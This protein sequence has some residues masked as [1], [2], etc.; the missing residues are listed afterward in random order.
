M[1]LLISWFVLSLAVWLTSLILP[2]FKVRGFIGA[3]VVAAVFGILNFLVGWFLF[4][5]IGIGTLGLGFLLAFIT[6]W[7]VDAILLKVT[8]AL[9]RSLEVKSFGWAMAA[10]F[11]MAMIGTVAE[12]M[13]SHGH[14]PYRF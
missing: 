14:H 8:G 10:A 3:I 4:V 7:I 1:G 9:M 11:V 5:V 6:R 13:L 2:G 12:H